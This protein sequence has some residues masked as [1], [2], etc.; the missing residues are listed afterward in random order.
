MTFAAQNSLKKRALQHKSHHFQ[1]KKRLKKPSKPMNTCG[2]SYFF[3]SA[4]LAGKSDR[5]LTDR[6]L[7]KR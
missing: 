4:D 7:I 5:P 1:L 3:H 6:P 2:S